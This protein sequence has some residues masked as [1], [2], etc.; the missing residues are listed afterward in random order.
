[1]TFDANT[2][3]PGVIAIPSALLITG[4]TQSLPL[5]VTVQVPPVTAAD[6]Y[7]VGQLVRLTVPRPYGMY[8]ANKLTA[9]IIARDVS[10][11]TLNIDSTRFDAFITPPNFVEQPATVAPAGSRNLQF[12]NTTG[13]VPFQSLNN[14]GN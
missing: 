9:Q 14:V 3:L 7:I 6:T 5:I 4:M 12:D 8:Q 13:L 10:T 1:M 11:L 2:Y